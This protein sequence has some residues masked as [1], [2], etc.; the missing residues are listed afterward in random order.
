MRTYT[1]VVEPDED[2]G[3]AVLVPALPGFTSAGCGTVHGR[4]AEGPTAGERIAVTDLD[5]D[6]V[7]AE[8]V[9]V[10]LDG[11]D[12]GIHWDRILHKA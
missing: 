2:G 3:L 1:I 9:A 11:A 6:T 10:R 8:V 4:A 5:A 12:I 7:E